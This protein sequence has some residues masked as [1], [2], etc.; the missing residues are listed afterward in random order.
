MKGR[1]IARKGLR[2]TTILVAMVVGVVAVILVV[3][4]VAAW[5]LH[6]KHML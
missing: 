6:K 3:C 2:I 4:I 1:G 5:V